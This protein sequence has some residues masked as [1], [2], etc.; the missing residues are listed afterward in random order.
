MKLIKTSKIAMFLV[1]LLVML[2]SVA[3]LGITPSKK[4]VEFTNDLKQDFSF[5][6]LNDGREF[7][8]IVYARGALAGYVTLEKNTI[9]ITKDQSEVK[10]NYK[11]D[12]PYSARTPGTNTIEIVVEEAAT[13]VKQPTAV[14]GKVAVVH[15]L[16]LKSPNEG[17]YATV[18]FS[19]NNPDDINNLQFTY[20]LFNEG[21]ETIKEFS[22]ELE[23]YKGKE[24][25]RTT[26][27]SFLGLE[28]GEHR[29]ETINY[30][31]QLEPG[32]YIAVTRINYDGKIMSAETKFVVGGSFLEIQAISSPDFVLGRINELD[33]AVFNRWSEQLKD[34]Y[35]EI[36]VKDENDKSYAI[37]KT[38]T[39]DVASNSGGILFGYWDTS[40]LSIGKYIVLVKAKYENKVSEKAFNVIVSMEGLTISEASISGRAVIGK[41]KSNSSFVSVLAM[42]FLILAI[43]NV[44]LIIYIRKGKQP[45]QQIIT[46]IMLMNL[47]FISLLI[48]FIDKLRILI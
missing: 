7:D 30:D 3:A 16:L 12:V 39:T 37:F 13:D 45:P 46:I 36:I 8:V 28:K 40:S 31:Q 48:N 24:L 26:E 11:V 47:S 5:N 20:A 6:I 2:S 35:A 27:Y 1:L 33:V 22:A 43:V 4:T 44:L 19:A 23:I 14:L 34:V 21:S 10:V 25:V 9:H 18:I 15:Q 41:T 32:E 42:A 17:K 38:P 29:K